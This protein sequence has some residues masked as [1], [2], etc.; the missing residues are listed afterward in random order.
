MQRQKLGVTTMDMQ[1][2]NHV[3]A[4][5]MRRV[6]LS[7]GYR[8]D[9]LR[10]T[11]RYLNEARRYTKQG[12]ESAALYLVSCALDELRQANNASLCFAMDMCFA[13]DRV[14]A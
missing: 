6:Q 10:A 14:R 4:R 13:M 8:K 5:V 7:Q 3:I 11:L 1:H 9:R 12:A 2:L